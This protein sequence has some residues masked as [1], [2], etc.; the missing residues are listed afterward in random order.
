MTV[1]SLPIKGCAANCWQHFAFKAI[2]CLQHHCLV[3]LAIKSLLG[4]DVVNQLN[5]FLRKSGEQT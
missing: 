3:D 4:L 5:T 2:F 1:K